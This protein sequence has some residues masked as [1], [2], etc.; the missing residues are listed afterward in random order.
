MAKSVVNI[1][2]QETSTE[3]G[4]LDVPGR[5]AKNAGLASYKAKKRGAK[6][7]S[8]QVDWPEDDLNR[9]FYEM[10]TEPRVH[11]HLDQTNCVGLGSSATL[12]KIL[13]TICVPLWVK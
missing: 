12:L 7:A 13:K 9:L 2:D 10:S 6:S 1:E 8:E 4:R 5:H 3:G 11:S